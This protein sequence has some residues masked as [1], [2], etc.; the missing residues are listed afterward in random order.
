MG[1]TLTQAVLLAVVLG[2]FSPLAGQDEPQVEPKNPKA[3][4]VIASAVQ[5]MGGDAYLG[6]MNSHSEGQYFIYDKDDRRAFSTFM[7]WTVYD[8][9]KSRFQSGEKKRQQV[10]IYNLETDQGWTLEGESSV[11]E[12]PPEGVA[13]FKQSVLRDLNVLLRRR[14]GDEDVHLYYYGP[15]DI[16]GGGEHEAVEIL[17]AANNSVVIFFDLRTHLPAKL[18][19]HVTNS[20]G[21]RQ[22][23]E[24]E[25]SNWHTIQGVHTP[26]RTDHY[27]E[28]KLSSQ[29]YTKS[30]TYNGALPPSLFLK[31]V[32]KK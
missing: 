25:Y 5:A 3:L 30:I 16:A 32:P 9:I 18:E 1:K 27:T 4:E 7:D 21:I 10:E 26:L 12:I 11:E 31:P 19:T 23:M 17:D 24:T 20:L 8:P 29:F 14:I 13:A 22:K 15:K 6:V 28:G 2:A